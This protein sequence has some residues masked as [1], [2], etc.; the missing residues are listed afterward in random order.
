MLERS[1]MKARA[2]Q[3]NSPAALDPPLV[4][5]WVHF[6]HFLDNTTYSKT[7]SVHFLGLMNS[8]TK[9][10]LFRVWGGVRVQGTKPETQK[11]PSLNL[12]PGSTYSLH[13]SSLF[14]FSQNLY[15][16]I[17]TIKLVSQKRNYN[18]DYRYVR[19]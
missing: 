5:E 8:A 17:L 9:F 6:A 13:C 18:G 15:Y 16:R 1:H 10:F 3:R 12:M 2:P 7:K 19:V 4:A 11:T 14:L